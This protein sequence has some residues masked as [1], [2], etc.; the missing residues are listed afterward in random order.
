MTSNK[1]SEDVI[2]SFESTFQERYQL[3]FELE[4]QWFH[5][6]LSEY[7]L[8]IGTTGYSIETDEFP[9]DFPQ[10]KIRTLGLMMKRSYCERELS[11]VNKIQNIIGKDVSL[12]GADGSRRMTKEELEFDHQRIIN[13]I[14]KQKQHCFD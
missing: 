13:L 4:M 3:P 12:T 14:N 5:D 1:T 8:E 7:E 2:A 10:Y 11:R 6:A 9:I